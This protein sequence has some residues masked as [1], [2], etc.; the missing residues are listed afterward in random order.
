MK[1]K[2]N[3]LNDN[4]KSEKLFKNIFDYK[5]QKTSKFSYEFLV[6]K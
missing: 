6:I 1:N 5:V 3:Y 4:H 2:N